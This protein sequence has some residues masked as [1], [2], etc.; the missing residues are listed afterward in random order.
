MGATL[1]VITGGWTIPEVVRAFGADPGAPD[2]LAEL[3]ADSDYE[4]MDSICVWALGDAV[5]VW[6]EG[7]LGSAL[8][9][10][11]APLSRRGPAASWY[12]HVENSDEMTLARNGTALL[13]GFQ[14][15]EEY[16]PEQPEVAHLFA[17]LDFEDFRHPMAKQM[18]VIERFTGFALRQADL[19][20]IDT[21]AV[22][23][24][25]SPSP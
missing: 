13:D 24:P 22:T 14:V 1:S 17:D 3:T 9:E 18:L 25:R 15:M 12:W 8:I 6:E 21:D 2:K 7:G 5:L 16:L 19:N 11:L 20:P 23:Y 10:V 4:P